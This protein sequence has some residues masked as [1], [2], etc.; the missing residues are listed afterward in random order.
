MDADLELPSRA[1]CFHALQHHTLLA[2]LP[3]VLEQEAL[4]FGE[5][6][7]TSGN[8]AVKNAYNVSSKVL[9]EG[10]FSSVK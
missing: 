2:S 4:S 8:S 10:G 7:P 9:G 3:F 6:A 1:P 5:I